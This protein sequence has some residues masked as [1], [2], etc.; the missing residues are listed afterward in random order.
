M[1]TSRELLN[2][3]QTYY[4]VSDSAYKN[5]GPDP[6][7][8]GI[9]AIH[10]G[11][12][13]EGHDIVD[14]HTAVKQMTR[15]VVEVSDIRPHQI[16]LDSGC[17]SGSIA[18]EVAAQEPMAKVYGIN[19]V[20]S[21]LQTANRAKNPEQVQLNFSRQDYLQTAFVDSSFD[22]IIFC[23]SLAH[24]ENKRCLM[25]E[26]YRILKPFGKIIIADC[27]G[28]TNDYDSEEKQ[29][30]QYFKTGMGVPS[31]EYGDNFRKSL[32]SIG[33]TNINF[34]DVTKNILPSALVGSIHAQQRIREG[35]DATDEVTRG[36]WAI[37]GIEKLMS[38]N[39]VGYYF[40]TA[41]K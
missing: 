27:F 31:I 1:S 40:L 37:I 14:N 4:L 8:K 5:W 36:R 10:M 34:Q 18:F 2:I 38:R 28:L 15:K 6:E 24:S 9:F 41:T 33:Y 3:I 39:K 22:R 20:T 17:G 7:R 16:V 35:R 21:Q 26:A 29:Y 32:E 30:L 19:I 25:Q 23:E 11:F 13:Y 12:H